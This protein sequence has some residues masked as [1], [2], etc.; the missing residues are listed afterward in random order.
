MLRSSDILDALEFLMADELKE[1]K[2]KAEELLKSG[3]HKTNKTVSEVLRPYFEKYPKCK[4]FNLGGFG[5]DEDEITYEVGSGDDEGGIVQGFLDD[6]G[7]DGDPKELFLDIVLSNEDSKAFYDL[8]DNKLMKSKD[9]PFYNS[10]EAETDDPD[11]ATIWIYNYEDDK[12]EKYYYFGENYD[13][14]SDAAN[15]CY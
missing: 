15:E 10:Y 14:W 9:F 4:F 8:F 6:E 11:T 13:Y 7:I 3:N 12:I 2:T 5:K 1:I